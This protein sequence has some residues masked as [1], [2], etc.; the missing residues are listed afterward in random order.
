VGEQPSDLSSVSINYH[1]PTI[2]AVVSPA[3]I[4]TRGGETFSLAGENFGPVGKTVNPVTMTYNNGDGVPHAAE[5]FVNVAHVGI[6]CLTVAGV[7]TDHKC[8]I[9][10]D[11]QSSNAKGTL[12]YEIPTISQLSSSR[13]NTLPTDGKAEVYV[14]GDFFGPNAGAD[15]IV[16]VNYGNN[17]ELA[18]TIASCSI[19]VPHERL[20]CLTVDGIGSSLSWT[21]VVGSQESDAAPETVSHNLPSIGSIQGTLLLDTRGDETVTLIG[22]DFGPKEDYNT[23]NSSYGTNGTE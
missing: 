4:D 8:V 10:V 11:G 2:S 9:S 6:S 22:N 21:V 1:A 16:S 3:R 14:D 5:C 23:P 15:N 17:A 20:K 7:G 12:D 19:E 13:I 18:F